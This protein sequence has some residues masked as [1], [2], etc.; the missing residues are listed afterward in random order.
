VVPTVRTVLG[1]VAAT[2]LG[3][4]YAHEHLVI[5][6][7]VPKIINPEIS[8]QDEAAAV[9]ELGACTRAGVR[10]VVDA[11]PADAGRNVTKL[12]AISR[13]AGVHII[14]ATGLHHARYYGE[15]H[16]GEVLAADELADL[17]TADVTDGVDLLDYGGPVVRR[18]PHRAGV[19]K[20]A[21]SAGGL[22][23]R[24]RR[25]FAAAALTARRTGVAVLTHCEGGQGGVE[26]VEVLAQHGV[27]PGRVVLSHTDK[28]AD[29]GYHRAIL[30]TG[31]N[32]VYDQGIRTPDGTERLVLAA[33]EAGHADQVL[34]GTDGA[35]RSLWQVLG[36]RPGLAALRTELGARLAAALGP[37]ADRLW[38]ANP[39]RIL[40]LAP[41]DAP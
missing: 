21:G 12:A 25:L 2:D 36:G 31:A 1:D 27:D 33:V 28:V 5:D 38:V 32:V 22:S 26:Q 30:A 6:G 24:D 40:A 11:M 8:L 3:V 4:C 34:L 16:W 10:A 41:T 15:R 37:D 7:G 39:A 14:V 17:F 35:R 19:V 18:T 29:L 13:A 20:V 9:E 23:G